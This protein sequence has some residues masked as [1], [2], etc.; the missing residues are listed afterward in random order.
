MI[1]E[2]MKKFFGCAYTNYTSYTKWAEPYCHKGQ[3][4]V[5]KMGLPTLA[6]TKPTLEYKNTAIEVISDGW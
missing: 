3:T 4:G 6:Y 5:G 2:M 1:L